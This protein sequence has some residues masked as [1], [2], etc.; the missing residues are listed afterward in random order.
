MGTGGW[1]STWSRGPRQGLIPT[2]SDSSPISKQKQTR[3]RE[4]AAACRDKPGEKR[5]TRERQE[6]GRK[7]ERL[8]PPHRQHVPLSIRGCPGARGQGTSRVSRL[9]AQ[10]QPV[11]KPCKPAESQG[12]T[13]GLMD[14]GDHDA[15]SPWA[16]P[17][18][19]TS[20]GENSKLSSF[21]KPRPSPAPVGQAV[22][23]RQRV[24]SLQT[25]SWFVLPGEQ[26]AT[27]RSSGPEPAAN[28]AWCYQKRRKDHA[29]L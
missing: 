15:A 17:T 19:F 10:Q 29:E 5:P 14:Q 11:P 12:S 2:P 13:W 25:T 26:A 1:G 24:P 16:Y 23:T 27:S 22:P 8:V 7:E 4:D 6:K 20:S 18:G 9:C 3:R 28:P 21:G